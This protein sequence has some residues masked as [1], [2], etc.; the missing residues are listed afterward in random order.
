MRINTALHNNVVMTIHVH[1]YV[2]HLICTVSSL[3]DLSQHLPPAVRQ[4]Y[5]IIHGL[6][7]SGGHS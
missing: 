5:H 7:H 3:V 4:P 6:L 1:V 2:A